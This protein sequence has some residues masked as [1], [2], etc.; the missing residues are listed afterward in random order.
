MELVTL[1]T[2]NKEYYMDLKQIIKNTKDIYM[3]DTMLE[4]LLDFE[5]VL[6]ELDVYVFDNW[7]HGEIIAGP[8][9]SKYFVNVTI[10]WPYAKMPDPDVVSRL[11]QYGIT[12][13]YNKDKL[14]VVQKGKKQQI[15]IWTVE[16]SMPKKLMYDIQQGS[17]EV[18]GET[19]DIEDLDVAYEQNLDDETQEFDDENQQ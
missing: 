5:R 7:K 14:D 9:F 18:E 6:D 4:Y 11:D 12:C 17:I 16:I 15:D 19:I 3:T 13:D 1:N 2:V 8:V 10:M